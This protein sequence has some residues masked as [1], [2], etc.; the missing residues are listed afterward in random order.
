MIILSE[1]LSA[2]CLT[3][4][5]AEKNARFLRVSGHTSRSTSFLDFLL[6]YRECFVYAGFIL[7]IFTGFSYCMTFNP[8]PSRGRSESKRMYIQTE[9]Y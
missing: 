9:L 4:S 8:N 5:S 2:C 1:C 7:S 3:I 6:P